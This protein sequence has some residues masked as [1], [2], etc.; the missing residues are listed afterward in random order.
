MTIGDLVIILRTNFYNL[1]VLLLLKEI[2]FINN[3]FIYPF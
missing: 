3:F 1:K 2:N